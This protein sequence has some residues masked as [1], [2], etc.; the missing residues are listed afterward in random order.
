MPALTTDT[1]RS[2]AGYR[3]RNAPVTSCYLDVD[4]RRFPRHQDYLHELDLLLRRTRAELNGDHSWS[5]ARDL[6]RI[7]N[8]VR[9]GLDRS[10]MR[11]L[12]FFSC[13]AEGFWEVI[14]LPVRVSSQVVVESSPHVRQLE[15]VLDEYERFGVLL[16]DRQRARMLVFE[17]GELIDRSE[18]FDEITHREDV[19]GHVLVKTRSAGQTNE[20][21]HQHLR[22]AA[23][24]AFHVFQEQQFDHLVV[25][26]PSDVAAELVACLHPYLR[27]RVVERIAVPVTATDEQ[28]RTVALEVEREVERRKEKALVDRLRGAIGSG[29]RGASGLTATLEALVERRVEHLIV[30]QGFRSPG[31][32]CRTCGYL[33]RVGRS[34]PLCRRSMEQTSDI[35]EHAIE[36]AVA[37][38]CRVEVCVANAD[39]DVLGGIGALLR[40]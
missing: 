27:A 35:V 37:Q 31:W 18:V 16:A 15:S 22:H 17:L 14:E 2:L 24:V 20:V 9:G 12:A 30:S 40:Y 19:K 38:S 34:C 21:K 39:L 6:Q 32:H 26:A 28:V 7:E 4:G 11:G 13:S 10:R 33:G 5:V 36:E 1:V 29:R 8:H 3:G 25:G 23:D